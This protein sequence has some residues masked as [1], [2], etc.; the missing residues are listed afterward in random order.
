MIS[1]PRRRPRTARRCTAEELT[2]RLGEHVTHFASLVGGKLLW[3]ASRMREEAED[4][5]AEAQSIRRGEQPE[6]PAAEEQETHTRR[7]R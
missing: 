4:I 6:A 1:R 7:R 2:D 5:W 3:L